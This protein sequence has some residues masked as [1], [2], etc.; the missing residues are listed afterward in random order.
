MIYN[1]LLLYHLCQDKLI[2][3]RQKRKKR[4]EKRF[5]NY[6]GTW[7][8]TSTQ[9]FVTEN[10]GGKWLL[11]QKPG[12]LPKLKRDAL[13]ETL[14]LQHPTTSANV[15]INPD[16]QSVW[17]SAE[18]YQKAQSK[19]CNDGKYVSIKTIHIY[20]SIYLDLIIS[21]YLSILT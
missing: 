21:I 5:K 14:P 11:Q 18:L 16:H 2:I 1:H 8:L 12:K 15:G 13:H 7:T 9:P 4:K 20:L 3:N 17:Q 10:S 19:T 6:V